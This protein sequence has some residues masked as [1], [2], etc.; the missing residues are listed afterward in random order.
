MR[1]LIV[2][3]LIKVLGVRILKPRSRAREDMRHAD[4]EEGEEEGGCEEG[5]CEAGAGVEGGV[6]GHGCWSE[7]MGVGRL[8]VVERDGGCY[9]RWG[10][11]LVG[12][13]EMDGQGEE[14][15]GE[16]ELDG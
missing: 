13:I 16:G 8:I 5:G 2:G 9:E 3:G 11:V 12:I 15:E 10:I 6:G 1:V 14:G 7:I 4:N